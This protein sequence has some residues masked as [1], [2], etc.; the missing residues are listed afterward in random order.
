M[1]NSMETLW[2]T[3]WRFL[4]E[5]LGRE[6]PNYPVNSTFEYISK[7]NEISFSEFCSPVFIAALF[8]IAKI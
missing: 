7:G 1:E 2:K 5:K 6:L 3:V 8:T 4:H